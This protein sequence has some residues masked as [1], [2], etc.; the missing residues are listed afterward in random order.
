MSLLQVIVFLFLISGGVCRACY[1]L[2]FSLQEDPTLESHLK[3]HKDAVTCVDFSPNNKQLGKVLSCLNLCVTVKLTYNQIKSQSLLPFWS[4]DQYI[5]YLHV[6]DCFN[7]SLCWATRLVHCLKW[8]I[9]KYWTFSL[10]LL[11][12]LIYLHYP[13]VVHHVVLCRKCIQFYFI[14]LIWMPHF[15]LHLP[16]ASGS[17]DKTLMIWHLGSKA[18]AFRFVGHQDIITGVHFSPTSNLVATSSK[19]RTVRLWKPSM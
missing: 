4:Q 19:D 16:L 11:I 3:G 14:V 6:C 5:L 9:D 7:T 17:V 18:R 12:Q 1:W 2:V 10:F 8:D 13:S 15:C